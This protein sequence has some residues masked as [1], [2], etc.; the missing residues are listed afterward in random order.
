MGRGVVRGI[1]W[2][3]TSGTTADGHAKGGIDRDM[4]LQVMGGARSFKHDVKR[5]APCGLARQ[6]RLGP[7]E[8]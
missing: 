3:D 7:P 2:C 4:P 6:H 8:E 1:Q 5:R